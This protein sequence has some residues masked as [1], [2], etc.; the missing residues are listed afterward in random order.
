LTKDLGDTKGIQEPLLN[1]DNDFEVFEMKCNPGLSFAY[2][3]VPSEG[4]KEP[5]LILTDRELPE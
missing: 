5:A 4:V 1:R 2:K 3:K